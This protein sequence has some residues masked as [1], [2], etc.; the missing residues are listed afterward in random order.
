MTIGKDVVI[1]GAGISGI[2]AAHALAHSG[3]RNILLIDERPPLTLTS[4]QSS[5]CYRNWWPDPAML[6]LMNRS[7]DLMEQLAAESG[8]ALRMNRRGYLYVTA[9]EGSLTLRRQRWH[10]IS[11][12]GAGPLRVHTESVSAYVPHAADGHEGQPIG[13]DLLLD[14]DLIRKHFPGLSPNIVAAL[15]VRRAGWLSAQQFGMLLLERALALGVEFASGK[16]TGVSTGGG[17]IKEVALASGERI[18]CGAFVNAAG[19]FLA[20][21]ARMQD[22]ELP[23]FCELH[24]KAVVRDHLGVVARNAPLL[25]W[26]DPQLLPWADD[27]R[28]HLSSDPETAWLTQQFP[29]G[30]HTRPEGSA[31]SRTILMLWEY[32]RSSRTEPVWPL[33]LDLTFPEVALRGL[34]AMLP[35]LRD[36]FGRIPRAQL[37]GGHYTKTPENRPIVGPTA[38]ENSFII[39]AS[40]GF[41]I[42]SAC[43]AAEL[44]AQHVTGAA[45]PMYASDF[46]LARY[47][48]PGYLDAA[49]A[50]A[51]NGQL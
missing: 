1:C 14:P 40:S 22:L 27:E 31:E 12:L 44:L 39:G 18:G 42:M 33:S 8:N 32:R 9:D 35:R 17:R 49:L 6:A 43:A 46:A 16:I 41:G 38:L 36:Y 25:I 24:F 13:A 21:V 15:H 37:D 5:E 30:V 2:A 34:S 28:T 10:R 3:L 23:V 45:L 4:A 48:Q 19:P 7:I 51:E 26:S 11:Q 47:D 20:P 29:A 50:A